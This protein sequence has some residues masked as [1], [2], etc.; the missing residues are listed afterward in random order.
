MT[1]WKVRDGD[2]QVLKWM[3]K[4]SLT[5]K[6]K[7]LRN[8]CIDEKVERREKMFSDRSVELLNGCTKDRHQISIT[9]MLKNG[10]GA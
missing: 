1:F 9:T 4:T 10:T 5:I 3:I 2:L 7:T 8:G 6:Q